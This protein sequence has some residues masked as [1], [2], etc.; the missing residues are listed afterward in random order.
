MPNWNQV[1]HELESVAPVSPHDV[2]RR[3]YL[4]QLQ[5]HTKR[6]IICYYSGF[7]QKPGA[8]NGAISDDDKNGLMATVH[9]LDR[10]LGL[11]LILHT[12]G[13]DLAATESIVHYLRTMF[14]G[15]I[16]AVIPQ[17]AMS[18]GTMIACAATEILMG[19][20]S[21]IG[22]IDPQFGGIPAHGVLEE[23]D[24]AVKAI[25]ADP[26]SIPIWQALIS[27]YHP[28]FIGECRKA[29]DL[30]DKIV[31]S[32]LMTGMFK[33]DAL[34]AQKAA[35]IVGKLNNHKDTL[36][37]SRHIH[38]DEA[39]AMGLKIV[40]LEDDQTLQDLTL[41]VH[42]CYMHT[43]ANSQAIKIIENH[44]GNAIIQNIAAQIVRR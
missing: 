34:A 37:H 23:L 14:D 32:W 22:P 39:I 10:T 41:T 4:E 20:Q 7:L 26:K 35:E 18:A 30:A 28:T 27:K 13:G 44:C 29:I 16:R 43:L 31:T 17:I 3:K 38:M 36:T 11:D 5:Q 40:K 33:G 19:K 25:T 6:N 42:H 24:E 15:N 2:V 21:S 1:L 9:N 12:P 8:A